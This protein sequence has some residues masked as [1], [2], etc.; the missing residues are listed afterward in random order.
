MLFFLRGGP[1]REGASRAVYGSGAP[2]YQF[3]NL[4]GI[5]TAVFAAGSELLSLRLALN[6]L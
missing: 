1:G 2:L 6:V 5:A 4:Y 3:A